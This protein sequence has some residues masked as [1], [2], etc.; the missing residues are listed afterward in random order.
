MLKA[1]LI[2]KLRSGSYKF[3]P[4]G[5][6]IKKARVE[7]GKY[8]CACCG[9]IVGAKDFVVD[10]IECV[11]P[12]ETGFTNWDDYITRMFCDVDGYQILC[13]TCNTSKTLVEREM[14]KSYRK[15]RKEQ[16]E[17]DE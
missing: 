17:E 4:R 7:R 13:T 14:R 11:V 1:F 10:H 2:P 8:K 15:L 5:E 12:I 6:A 16:G 9:E 3:P